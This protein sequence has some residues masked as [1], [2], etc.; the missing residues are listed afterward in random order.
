ME[1]PHSCKPSSSPC[2]APLTVENRSWFPS[3]DCGFA[4]IPR[5]EAVQAGTGGS[6]WFF[7]VKP[8]RRRKDTDAVGQ[9]IRYMD[10]IMMD[11]CRW[12][13]AGEDVEN[14]KG[15]QGACN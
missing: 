12:Q 15:P 5:E 6:R 13:V 2:G 3:Q 9:R 14:L 8:V 1:D 4:E 11:P 7:G 10:R